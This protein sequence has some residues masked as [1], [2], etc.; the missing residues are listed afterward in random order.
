[1]QA[2]QLPDKNYARH[3]QYLEKAV[4]NIPPFTEQKRIVAKLESI[5]A[6]IDAVKEQLEM[7]VSQTKSVFRQL[8]RA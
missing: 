3:Y 5:F 2:I 8:E 7:L 4:M 1:M 6:Q